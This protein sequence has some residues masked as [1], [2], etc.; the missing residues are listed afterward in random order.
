M[1]FC[2]FIFFGW[3]ANSHLNQMEYL[4]LLYGV[5]AFD[6]FTM[7]QLKLG[8]RVVYIVLGSSLAL[9]VIRRIYGLDS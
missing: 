3:V 8:F 9:V 7:S 1:F 5:Q 2:L 6:L 4:C